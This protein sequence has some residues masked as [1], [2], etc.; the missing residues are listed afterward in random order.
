MTE[1]FDSMHAHYL[2]ISERYQKML[3]ALAEVAS[4]DWNEMERWAQQNDQYMEF[5]P[6]IDTQTSLE[7]DEIAQLKTIA[8]S[9][10]G[11]QDQVVSQV[12]AAK[13]ECAQGMQ[14]QHVTKKALRAYAQPQNSDPRFQDKT[15]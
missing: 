9:L 11:L 4:I 12:L 13:A 14:Q 5:I 10:M 2:A 3:D 15:L 1:T 7:E 6:N 8:E